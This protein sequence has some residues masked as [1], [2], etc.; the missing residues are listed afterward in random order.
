MIQ[1]WGRTPKLNREKISA[2][3]DFSVDAPCTRLTKYRETAEHEEGK[4]TDPMHLST[5]SLNL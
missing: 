1:K 2:Q 5:Q 4:V 3:G